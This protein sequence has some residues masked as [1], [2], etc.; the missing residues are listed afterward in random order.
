[1]RLKI[2][3][4][5]TSL[6]RK[7]MKM[8]VSRFTSKLMSKQLVSTLDIT[9]NLKTMSEYDGLSL[10]RYVYRSKK[11]TIWIDPTMDRDAQIKVLAHELTHIKQWARGEFYE[12]SDGISY[13]WKG[14][15]IRPKAEDYWLLPW[16][17][18][19]NGYQESLYED[20]NQHATN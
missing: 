10:P 20:Y 19:A 14:K 9:I 6:S 4:R 1:M 15:R 8:L 17:V 16:E 2:R 18:E 5:P 13:S 11:F 7:E 3:G 12:L